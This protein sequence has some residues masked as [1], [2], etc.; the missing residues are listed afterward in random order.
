MEVGELEIRFAFGAAAELHDAVAA[1]DVT[2]W[3]RRRGCVA[4][5]FAAGG[6]WLESAEVDQW[7]SRRLER[8]AAT[9]ESD[10][11]HQANGTPHRI[12]QAPQ[13]SPRLVVIAGLFHQF[14]AVQPP[15]LG[16]QAAVEL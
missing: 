14:F 3:L 1:E 5:R 8:Q 7:P 16:E 6:V 11:D 2:A 13:T 12:F 15:T 10:V 4:Q 9:V